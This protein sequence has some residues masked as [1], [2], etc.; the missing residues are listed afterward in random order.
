M[1]KLYKIQDGILRYHEAWIHDQQLFEH[2][3]VAGDRGEL[4][5]HRLE[6]GASGTNPVE[7]AL[8]TAVHDGFR[9]LE[10]DEHSTLVIEY[11]ISGMGTELD[12]LKRHK[13][14]DHVD[15]LLGWTGLG[16]CDGGSTG[17]GTMEVFCLV[18]DFD[19]ARRVIADDIAKSGFSGYSRIYR[20]EDDA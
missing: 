10:P 16:H 19:I 17:S 18:A 7:K 4:R 8:Q 13:L 9:V 6:P 5:H 11:P 14:E 2:W 20:L 15:Q 1:R 3:G 12:L